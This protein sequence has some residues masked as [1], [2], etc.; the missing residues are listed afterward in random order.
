MKLSKNQFLNFEILRKSKLFIFFA[1]LVSSIIF[2]SEPA[3]STKEFAKCSSLSLES[4]IAD[5]TTM[6]NPSSGEEQG[7]TISPSTFKVTAHELGICTEGNNPYSASGLDTSGCFTLWSSDAGEEFNLVDANGNPEIFALDETTV[8]E[9]PLGTYKYAY[10]I[11]DDTI[12]LKATLTLSGETWKTSS[13]AN[14]VEYRLTEKDSSPH[15]S[16]GK[17]STSSADEFPTRVGIF[18]TGCKTEDISVG[19]AVISGLLLQSNKTDVATLAQNKNNFNDELRYYCSGAKYIAGVQTLSTPI[20]V[21]ENTTS[22]TLS[23]DTTDTGV[24]VGAYNYPSVSSDRAT[25]TG[26]GR[27]YFDVGPFIVRFTVD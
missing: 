3:Y 15:A 26:Y 6:L 24:W 20:T 21:T 19:G 10:I 12:R 18:A 1:T 4:S 8:N 22:A 2:S 5:G 17:S 7:C 14:H 27:I 13:E 11:I 25:D 9:P 23:F 16:I